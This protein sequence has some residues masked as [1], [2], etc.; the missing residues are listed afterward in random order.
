MI[1]IS[2]IRMYLE[3]EVRDRMAFFKPYLFRREEQG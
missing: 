2:M 3:K 1:V